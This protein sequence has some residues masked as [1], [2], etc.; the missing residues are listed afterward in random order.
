MPPRVVERDVDEFFV[1]NWLDDPAAVDDTAGIQA[2]CD[3]ISTQR[4]GGILRFDGDRPYRI[5]GLVTVRGG[6]MFEGVGWGDPDASSSQPTAP[7]TVIECTSP[8]S[9][10]LFKGPAGEQIHGGGVRQM[11]IDGLNVAARLVEAQSTRHAEFEFYARRCTEAALIL[12]DGNGRLSANNL[13][14]TLVYRPGANAATAGS[15]GVAIYGSTGV[16]AGDSGVTR[17]TAKVIDSLNPIVIGDH[18]AGHFNHVLGTVVMPGT[19]GNVLGV[20]QPRP[21]RKNKIEHHNGNLVLGPEVRDVHDL[22][23]SEPSIVRQVNGPQPGW[24]NPD[25]AGYWRAID[26]RKGDVHETAVF[27]MSDLHELNVHG[28]YLD[29]GATDAEFSGAQWPGVNLPSGG[30]IAWSFIAPQRW[31]TG[32]LRELVLAHVGGG[33]SIDIVTQSRTAGIG[34]GIITTPATLAATGGVNV[35]DVTRTRVDTPHFWANGDS[36]IHVRVTNTGAADVGI[37]AAGL[38]YESDGPDGDVGKIWHIPTMRLP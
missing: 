6:V 15:L 25:V 17:T 37:I 10:I 9:G 2:A 35:T 23:N 28:A 32:E 1:N 13:I 33:T 3:W 21:A 29:G 34:G 12:N 27:Q 18:D 7:A 16:A 22:I 31:Y 8:A 5:G 24:L 4:D 14:D 11:V 26:R 36:V 30:S 20:T 38:Y 19:G